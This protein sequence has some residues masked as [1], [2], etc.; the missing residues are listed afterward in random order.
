MG[1]GWKWDCVPVVDMRPRTLHRHR[2]LEDGPHGRRRALERNVG[3]L[4][5]R[6]A[7][8]QLPVQLLERAF[9]LNLPTP[10]SQAGG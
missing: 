4:V 5:A 9:E 7:Q 10:N 8:R 3:T 6:Q 2:Q 1:V